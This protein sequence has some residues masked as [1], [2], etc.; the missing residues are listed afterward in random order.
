[1]KTT[2]TYNA[3]EI[4]RTVRQMPPR[5]RQLLVS[6]FQLCTNPMSRGQKASGICSSEMV[7]LM[8]GCNRVSASISFMEWPPRL[9]VL[10][11]G[12]NSASRVI[13]E[14]PLSVKSIFWLAVSH[15]RIQPASVKARISLL[16]SA[17]VG[18][19]NAKVK[20]AITNRKS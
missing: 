9:M 17:A 14:R 4:C 16:M 10:K 12:K 3:E 15:R 6:F 7:S 20:S 1:M 8:T 11:I 18:F 5:E 13:R 19:I 2:W